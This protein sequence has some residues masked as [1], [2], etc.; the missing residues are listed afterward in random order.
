MDLEFLIRLKSNKEV[1]CEC[2][3]RMAKIYRR[4]IHYA[5]ARQLI[6][7]YKM[8]GDKEYIHVTALIMP[9]VAGPADFTNARYWGLIEPAYHVPDEK[10]SSGKWRLTQKGV[11]FVQNKITLPE[12]ANIFD[13]H[14]RELEGEQINIKDALGTKFNYL[15]MMA[16]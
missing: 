3:G 5:L 11:D 8:G 1:R 14:L 10:K 4:K 9:S 15:E 16:A 2:C 12:Y 7:M 6:R 13:G